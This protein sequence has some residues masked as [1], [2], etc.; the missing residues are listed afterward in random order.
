M[1]RIPLS[2]GSFLVALTLTIPIAKADSLL[3]SA[4]FFT[5]V[6]G[7]GNLIPI[8][9]GVSCI[10]SNRIWLTNFNATIAPDSTMNVIF[11]IAGGEDGILYDVFANGVLDFSTNRANA[12]VWMGQGYHCTT[13]V[14]NNLPTTGAFLILGTPEDDDNDG[15]TSA[16]EWLVSK[17]NPLLWD[18]DGDGKGDGWGLL[19]GMDPLTN[20]FPGPLKLP[21][22]DSTFLRIL[23]PDLLEMIRISSDTTVWDFTTNTPAPDQFLVTSAN[24][25]IDVTQVGY[26][27]RVLYASQEQYDLRIENTLYLRLASTNWATSDAIVAVTT[28]NTTLWPA[29]TRFV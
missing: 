9:N 10:T 19:P 27:R 7:S 16:Y 23:A 1:K 20:D 11:T 29:P 12:W 4:A 26:K 22:V 28:N 14:I 3:P 2:F 18:T 25:T 17:T 21:A 24:S 5:G 8:R 13:Y 6:T 15:L